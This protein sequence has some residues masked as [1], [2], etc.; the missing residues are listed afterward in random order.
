MR[1][2]E[3]NS[4]IKVVKDFSISEGDE[5][6]FSLCY[7]PFLKANN[8]H[9]YRIL[10]SLKALDYRNNTYTCEDLQMMTGFS[11]MELA[12][13]FS[14][15]EAINLVTSYREE[16]KNSIYYLEELHP[17]ASP[18][19]FFQ[20]PALV[21]LLINSTNNQYF[22]QVK[23]LFLTNK[24]VFNNFVKIETSFKDFYGD[25]IMKSIP[26]QNLSQDI[27][28]TEIIDKSYV[29][30]FKITTNETNFKKALK[31]H[32]LTF[33]VYKANLA[34]ILNYINLYEL[35][36]DIYCDFLYESTK[37]NKYFDINTFL[38]KVKN[39]LCTSFEKLKNDNEIFGNNNDDF[40]N[41]IA[42]KYVPGDSEFTRRLN[43][44]INMS[45]VNF[46]S[47]EFANYGTGNYKLALNIVDKLSIDFC[48]TE[49]IINILL[50]YC[51]NVV[52]VF[53]MKYIEQIANTICLKNLNSASSVADYLYKS[54]EIN[55]EKKNK[56]NNKLESTKVSN[57]KS[58]DNI[59]LEESGFDDIDSEELSLDILDPNK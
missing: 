4:I 9:L 34:Q 17:V 30:T 5:L 15:L 57:K 37:D 53:N 52:K 50:D 31:N 48:L 32:Q 58:N 14:Y 33:S 24:N 2:L 21:S 55:Q 11:K 41:N 29:K 22:Q 1:E 23:N 26:S 27:E 36:E 13:C 49:P 20:D 54:Y 3:N 8:C 19:K 18:S 7:A 44:I 40:E 51:K 46:L 10:C 25:S 28:N 59:Y 43:R 56:Y 42:F 35:T 16:K 45:T 39:Y 47:K 6:L 38:S 12:R